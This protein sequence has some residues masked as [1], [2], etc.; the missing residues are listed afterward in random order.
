MIIR[1]NIVDGNN[2]AMAPVNEAI[3]LRH[4]PKRT[5]RGG[6]DRRQGIAW[7]AIA[8]G[9]PGGH[10]M[11]AARQP[12]VRRNPPAAIGGL[13]HSHR[14][15]VNTTGCP[16]D[17]RRQF[18]VGKATQ[19]GP[20]PDPE[21]AFAVF[22][23]CLNAVVRKAIDLAECQKSIAFTVGQTLT[24]ADP[25]SALSIHKESLNAVGWQTIMDGVGR[26]MP[27][28]FTAQTIALGADPEAAIRSP[29]Q[30]S[31]GQAGQFAVAGEG[32]LVARLRLMDQAITA[33]SDPDAALSIRD[34]AD[35]G[36]QK[37][38]VPQ[39]VKSRIEVRET[40]R[41][42]IPFAPEPQATVAS[43]AND[44]GLRPQPPVI[45]VPLEHAVSKT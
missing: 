10:T 20:G 1:E 18:R 29:A 4:Q 8:G 12:R 41:A 40:M 11:P 28:P 27:M 39:A 17:G 25:H 32:D 43:F 24:C 31:E 36:T 16:Q 37:T 7:Q 3:T 44:I 35:A 38:A 22:E 9:E 30:R 6:A 45:I 13:A 42:L 5:I 2:F 19:A 23:Q 14:L 15:S 34:H 21:I 33:G 26:Q